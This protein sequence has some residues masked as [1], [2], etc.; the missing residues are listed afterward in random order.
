MPIFVKD[1]CCIRPSARAEAGPRSLMVVMMLADLDRLRHL[2]TTPLP[3]SAPTIWLLPSILLGST[4]VMD[5]SRLPHRTRSSWRS[6]LAIAGLSAL[7][8]SDL[9]AADSGSLSCEATSSSSSR[10]SF[11]SPFVPSAL[12][13]PS[14]TLDDRDPRCPPC[15]NCNLPSFHCLNTGSCRPQDGQCD[16]PPGFGGLDCGKPLDGSLADGRERYVREG[17]EAHCKDGWSGLTCNGN[18]LPKGRI[19]SPCSNGAY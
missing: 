3:C 11:F 14:A 9:A 13:V 2:A 4:A 1:V 6:V 19:K 5:P 15:F 18:Y 10:I 16:C 8:C 7:A 17:N 12:S